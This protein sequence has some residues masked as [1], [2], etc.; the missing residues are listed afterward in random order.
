MFLFQPDVIR[1]KLAAYHSF[2]LEN[3]E[4]KST[5]IKFVRSLPFILLG[6]VLK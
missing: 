2:R 4:G 3:L 1:R 6:Y 5:E